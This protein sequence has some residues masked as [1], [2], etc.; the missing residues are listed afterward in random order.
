MEAIKQHIKPKALWDSLWPYSGLPVLIAALLLLQAGQT[1]PFVLLRSL[2][3]I[4]FGYIAAVLDIK[5]RRIPNKIVLAMLASWVLF[6]T[7][8]LFFDTEASVMM[9]RDSMLGMLIGG[10]MFLLVYLIS[11]KGLGGGDVKFMAAAGLYVGFEGT[12]SSILLGTILAAV[13]GLVLILIRKIGRKDAIP[14]APF[15]F[16]GIVTVLF[17]YY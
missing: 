14:L 15:L 1:D 10:G 17:L 5:T 12:I 4:V 9:L 3:I 6:M 16:I 7:P 8:R 13:T 2:L 11:K